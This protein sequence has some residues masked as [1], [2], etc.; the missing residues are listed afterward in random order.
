MTPLNRNSFLQ[1]KRFEVASLKQR[2]QALDQMKLG[3]DEN[4]FQLTQAVERERTRSG[5]GMAKLAMPRILE[6]MDERRINM[7][8]TRAELEQD[9]KLLESQLV[10]AEEELSAEEVAADQ[11]RRHA[12]KSA[13]AMAAVRREQNQMR[14]HL[15]R[16]AGSRN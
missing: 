13:E 3:L 14:R 8:K 15:R 2:L 5:S 11:R 6:V 16:H 9:R 4:I 10:A 7:E 1:A 12:A